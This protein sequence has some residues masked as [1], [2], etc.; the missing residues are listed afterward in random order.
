M[1]DFWYR[2]PPSLP[3]FEDG[4]GR[5]WTFDELLAGDPN[6]VRT[7]GQHGTACWYPQMGGYVGKAL[8]VPT[9]AGCVDVYVWHDGE[10]PFAGDDNTPVT[11]VDA[12]GWVGPRRGPVCLHHCDGAQFVAFGEFLL[13]ISPRGDDEA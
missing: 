1:S 8:A 10:F 2:D 7:Y 12:N 6:P 13:S 4:L 3:P 9:G 11:V 5:Q